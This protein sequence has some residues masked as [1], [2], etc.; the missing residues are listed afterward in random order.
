MAEEDFKQRLAR[1]KLLLVDVDGVLTDG[2][3]IYGDHGDELKF[4]NVQDGFGLVLLQRA[5]IPSIIITSKKSRINQRRAKEL[6]ITKI[7]QNVKSK[8]DVYEKLIKK[9]KLEDSEVCYIADDLIDIPI[10]RRVGAAAAVQNAV[11]D[12]KGICHY[13]TKRNGGHGAVREVI[14]MLLKSQGKW[15]TITEGYFKIS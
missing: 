8:L 5:G 14:D 4:F 2:R 9:M 6:K 3:I 13:V 10:L 11:E 1:V 12:V 15:N 7:F